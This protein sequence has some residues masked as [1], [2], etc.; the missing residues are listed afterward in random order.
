SYCRR[1]DLIVA[2]TPQIRDFI[3]ETYG[4]AG[5]P[6]KVIPTGIPV[7][8]YRHGHRLWLRE[9]LGI[10]SDDPV[11]IFVGR[12]GREK[13]VAFLLEALRRVR[14]AVDRVHLVLVGDG[15]DRPR[16]ERMAREMGLAAQVH[17]TGTFTRDQV[18]QAYHGADLFVI[19]STTETQGLA[20]LEAMAAGLPVVGVDAP[21][22]HDMVQN[23]VQGLLRRED[24]TEFAQA[25]LSLLEDP[26]KRQLFAARARQ[27]AESLSS[28]EMALRLVGAYQEL[29]TPGLHDTKARRDSKIAVELPKGVSR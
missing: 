24:P 29:L 16:L 8:D 15:P 27:R 21:G 14:E 1:A 23:G 19:A 13:N 28:R 18:I 26:A 5:K 9:R 20:T 10:P 22:T 4:L 6:V 7:D 25:V 11:L 12:L 3:V 17:F 2:P